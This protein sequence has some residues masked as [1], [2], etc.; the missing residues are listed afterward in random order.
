MP[1]DQRSF[2]PDH[3]QP[4]VMA[5]AKRENGTVIGNVQFDQFGLFSNPGIARRGKECIA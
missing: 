3:D 2:W 1:V 5:S 4:D